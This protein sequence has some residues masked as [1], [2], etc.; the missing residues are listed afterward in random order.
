MIDCDLS[1]ISV[2][3][4]GVNLY[5]II[6]DRKFPAKNDGKIARSEHLYCRTLILFLNDLPRGGQIHFSQ[7]NTKNSDFKKCSFT[8]QYTYFNINVSISMLL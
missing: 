5:I 1:P 4:E 3:H 6:I 8:N 2:P 7:N